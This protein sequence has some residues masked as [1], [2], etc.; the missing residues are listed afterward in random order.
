MPYFV[1]ARR[2]RELLD[3]DSFR[4]E[5]V[6]TPQ[7]RRSGIK[8]RDSTTGCAAWLDFYSAVDNGPVKLIRESIQHHSAPV[9][10]S[11]ANDEVT[12]EERC[13][14]SAGRHRI[15]NSRKTRS[16]LQPASHSSEYVYLSS[17][18]P[19]VESRSTDET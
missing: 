11:A 3:S 5:D 14:T 4:V 6:K 12:T 16:A 8:P 7:A 2:F 15:V 10:V 19:Y 13:G 9:I 17:A 18:P 1:L